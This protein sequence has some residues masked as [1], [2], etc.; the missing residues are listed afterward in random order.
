MTNYVTKITNET[1]YYNAINN[2]SF[3][4]IDFFAEWCGVSILFFCGESIT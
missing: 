3:V 1:E 4:V 2:N